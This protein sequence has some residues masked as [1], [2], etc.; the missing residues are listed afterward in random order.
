MTSGQTVNGR[1]IDP[2]VEA[3]LE[4]LVTAPVAIL[5]PRYRELYKTD[6]PLAF[7]P[8][9]LRRSIAQRIQEKAYGGLPRETQRLLN[10]M[11]KAMMQGG[12]TGRLELPRRIKPGSELV[13][14]WKGR[15]Y[16]SPSQ[17]M[18]ILMR[19]PSLPACRRS[20]TRSPAPVGTARNSSGFGLTDK[21]ETRKE[22]REVVMPASSQKPV[23]CAIYTRKSTEHGLELEFNSLD[24]QREACEAYIKSQT[25]QGWRV[26]PQPYDDPAYSGGTLERPALKQLLTDIEWGLID[27][28]VVYKIDRLTRSLADFAKLVETFDRKSISFVAVTQQ[29]NTTSSMGRLTLNVLLSFAQFERELSSERVRDKVAASRRKGKWTGGTVP[30]GYEAKDKKLVIQP[31]EAETVRTIFNQYLQLK[32]FSLLVQDLDKRGIVT[33]RR[34]TKVP[35]YRGGIPFTYGPLAHL[36]KNRIYLGEIHHAGKWFSAEHKP[37]LDKHVFDKVQMLLAEN[38][39]ATQTKRLAG[40]ALLAG[41]LRDDRGNQMSPSFTVKNGVRYRFYVSRALLQGRKTQAG[42]IAR[43]PAQLVED[44][45]VSA[46]RERLAADAQTPADNDFKRHVIDSVSEVVI[47]PNKITIGLQPD[48]AEVL[49]IPWQAPIKNNVGTT[50]APT[51]IAQTDPKLLQAIVR[52]NAWLRDLRSGKFDSV[53]GLAAF[54]K[55]HPKVVRQELRYAFMAPTINN[56]LLSD[57]Q[58]PELI[59]A[60]IPKRLPLAWSG[61]YGALKV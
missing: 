59:L 8:D 41:K 3:E 16:K 58:P 22:R 31:K 2:K 17:P 35:K 47:C 4:Q 7:G 14:T 30:L 34:D 20:P 18:A 27:V 49:E 60:R 5:R 54:V 46:M 36:L 43:I 53:E 52:A 32:S 50:S 26:L 45:V 29:F 13:R 38:R 19:G 39:I 51:D 21:M 33:K 55:L 42:S 25:S 28:I 10:Q 44:I 61:Q 24:A 12:G 40:G 23:R 48:N 15:T 37:I 56:H 9:L 11:V 1:P 6:P 57:D